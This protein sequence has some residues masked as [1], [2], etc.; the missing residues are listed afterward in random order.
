MVSVVKEECRPATLAKVSSTRKHLGDTLKQRGV[1]DHLSNKI[2][3]CFSEAAANLI[4]HTEPHPTFIAVSLEC[5]DGAWMLHIEDDGE[6]WDPTL[7]DRVQS[8]DTFEEKEGGRGLALIHSLTDGLEYVKRTTFGA[9]RLTLKWKIQ[10]VA[11]KPSVLVVEDDDS[12][13]RLISAYLSEHFK[14]SEAANGQEALQFLMNNHVDLVI[15]DIRMPSMDGLDLKR[16][17]HKQTNTLLT[18]FIFL[19][20][21][22]SQEVRDNAMGLGIDDYILKPVTKSALVQSARRVL[23]RSEQIYRQLTDKVNHRI[24]HSLTPSLPTESRNWQIA[25]ATRN[26]GIGGGDLVLHRN[27][28]DFLMINMVDVMGHD[29]AAKFFSY[30]YGGYLRGLMYHVDDTSDPCGTLL[31]RLSDC[32]MDDNLLSQVILTC[33]SVALYDNATLSM[34]TAGHPPPIKVSVLGAELMDVGGIMPGVLYGADYQTLTSRLSSGER[35]ALYTDGLFEAADSTESRQVL[36]KAVMRE[37]ENTRSLPV[38]EAVQH[39][40]QVFDNYGDWHRDDAT[41]V[42]LEYAEPVLD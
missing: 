10:Q 36:E 21:A 22:D 13:R 34:A 17:L 41:I 7:A 35:I 5:V 8:L 37:L 14:V 23:H 30:A 11:T 20:Y 38:G 26:T 33:C 18:P 2:Q 28:D 24:T 32:A 40:M 31:S 12:Q 3:L 1:A 19:T 42:L 16:A 27:T 39:V 25:I 15:S 9:N 4:E 6:Y 29:V